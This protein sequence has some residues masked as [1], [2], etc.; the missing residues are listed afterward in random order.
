MSVVP[1]SD[2][3]LCAIQLLNTGST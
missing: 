1:S 2:V 3:F